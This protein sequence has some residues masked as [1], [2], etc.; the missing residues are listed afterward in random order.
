METYV[1]QKVKKCG[2]R[3]RWKKSLS[4]AAEIVNIMSTAPMELICFEYLY[5]KGG[6]KNILVITDY[7]RQYAQWI[8]SQNQTAWTD[9]SCPI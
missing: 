6:Y 3:I 7:F 9:R 1:E 2:L 5:L 8:P 4:T